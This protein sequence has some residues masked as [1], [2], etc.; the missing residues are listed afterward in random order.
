MATKIAFVN[1]GPYVN[2]GCEA[3]VRGT[4]RLF[5]DCGI[6]FSNFAYFSSDSQVKLQNQVDLGKLTH[7]HVN[8]KDTSIVNRVSKKIGLHRG[9]KEI[10]A[11]MLQLLDNSTACLSLGGDNYSLDYGYPKKM[12]ELDDTILQLKKPLVIWG[13]TIGPF[14]KDPDFEKIIMKHL[15]RT[16]AIFCREEESIHYLE[17]FG[18]GNKL[19]LMADPAF[20]ME[21]VAPVLG[22]R[23][24]VAPGSIG[25]NLSPI[26]GNYL[27]SYD[28]WKSLA[29]CFLELLQKRTGRKIYLVPHVSKKNNNDYKFMKEL[30]T[31]LPNRG[32]FI[33]IEDSYNAEETKWIISQFDVFCGARTHST[34]AALSSC[35][36]TLSL[37]YSMKSIGIN[38]MIYG[39]LDYCQ[40]VTS[41][42]SEKTIDVL[43]EMLKEKD[44][45]SDK[46]RLSLKRVHVLLN[47]SKI[48]LLEIVQ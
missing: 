25:V 16:E 48:K 36:P 40:S 30:L 27:E 4:M 8:R 32:E 43:V 9:G 21:P 19:I 13:A 39:N 5:F 1:N 22:R 20:L 38:K 14:S 23:I 47:D 31:K 35:V 46:I 7:F 12:M 34:I 44:R 33:L 28:K 18:L 45:I 41:F 37:S 10:D 3:I 42:S 15:M 6:E 24:C 17:S 29:S 11:K 26:I 2:R